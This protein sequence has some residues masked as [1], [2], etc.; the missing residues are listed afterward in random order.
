MMLE[1]FRVK[2]KEDKKKERVFID[3][4]SEFGEESVTQEMEVVFNVYKITWNL[5]I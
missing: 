2:E 4:N 5:L 3:H 1:A